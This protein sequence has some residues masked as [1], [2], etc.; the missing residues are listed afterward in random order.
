[1]RVA[2]K[3]RNKIIAKRVPSGLIL[4]SFLS[5]LNETFLGKR[6]CYYSHYLDNREL[7]AL[8]KEIGKFRVKRKKK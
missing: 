3:Y 1:M 4:L 6:F 7:A 5:P 8:K 2:A